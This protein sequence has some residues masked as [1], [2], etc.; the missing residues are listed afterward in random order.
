MQEDSA[1]LFPEEEPM[2]TP[3]TTKEYV[4]ALLTTLSTLLLRLF[5]DPFLNGHP[6]FVLA[7]AGVLIAAWYG[8]LKPG[9]LAV[10]LSCASVVVVLPEGSSTTAEQLAPA[11]IAVYAIVASASAVLIAKLELPQLTDSQREELDVRAR[12]RTLPAGDVISCFL[13]EGRTRRS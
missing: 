6:T 10:I 3:A 4:I 1:P 8:G 12:S 13:M 9:L 7:F 11:A 2:T 5:V